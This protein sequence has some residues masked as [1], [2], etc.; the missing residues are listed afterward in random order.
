MSG[1]DNFY[2]NYTWSIAAY[3]HQLYV[4]TMDGNYLVSEMALDGA[5]TAEGVLTV[6]GFQTE[7]LGASGPVAAAEITFAVKEVET[8]IRYALPSVER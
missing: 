7:T 6:G 4:G 1:F 8:T 5:V 3:G 2:N